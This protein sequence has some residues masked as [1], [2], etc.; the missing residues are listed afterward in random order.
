MSLKASGFEKMNKHWK[1]AAQDSLWALSMS[2]NCLPA[3]EARVKADASGGDAEI[4]MILL[5]QRITK[6][7][8][9]GKQT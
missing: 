8:P 5:L 1:A 9:W 4:M 6:L 2:Y 3:S 7:W